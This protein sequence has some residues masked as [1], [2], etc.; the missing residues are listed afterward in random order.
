MAAL[1]GK[2][3]PEIDAE[4]AALTCPLCGCKVA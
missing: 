1:Q 3:Q 4:V 2:P